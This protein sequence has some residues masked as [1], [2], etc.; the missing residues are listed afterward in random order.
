[1]LGKKKALIAM[2]GGVDSSVAAYLMSQEGYA[3][4]GA[5]MKLLG[6]KAEGRAGSGG[7]GEQALDGADSPSAHNAAS[8]SAPNAAN[9]SALGAANPNAPGAANPNAPKA[10]SPSAPGAANSNARESKA[11]C[12]LDDAEDA[13]AVAHRLGMPFYVFNMSDLFDREVIGRF[14]E[15]YQ[16]GRTPNPCIACNRFMKFGHLIRKADQIGQEYLATGHYVRTEYDKGSGRHLLLKGVDETK[17]QSYVLYALTQQQLGR[18]V[19]PL[20]G[21][22]K[23]HVREIAQELGF[24]NAKKRESQDICFVADGDYAGFLKSYT[25]CEER[26]G[27]FVDAAGVVLGQHQGILHY[28]IGQRKGLGLAGPA[29]H[30]VCDIIPETD[31]VVVGEERDLYTDTLV[32]HDI[33]LIPFERLDAPLRVC[34]KTRY[35]QKEQ[36]A[37]LVQLD[38]D[39]IQVVF[40]EPQRAIAKG[41]AVVAYLGEMV[42]GGGTIA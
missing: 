11:C 22:R 23:A 25:G 42:I 33:N 5:M 27:Q 1:M 36:P 9:P 20:G 21:L 34:A 16:T 32:A 41:Q 3:C 2:S 13:R 29:P 7:F 15:A 17:D 24:V 39:T 28:T 38:E 4:V 31:T 30:Y 8:P 19:F 26:C 18:A 35:K 14:V 37:T 6:E 40:D 12:T 10:A